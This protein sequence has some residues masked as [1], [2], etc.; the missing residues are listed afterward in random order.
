MESLV[1]LQILRPSRNS[2]GTNCPVARHIS[3]PSFELSDPRFIRKNCIGKN[4]QEHFLSAKTKKRCQLKC[5]K[6]NVSMNV[7]CKRTKVYILYFNMAATQNFLVAIRLVPVSLGQPCFVFGLVWSNQIAGKMYPEMDIR[8]TV[9]SC[10]E[11]K[12]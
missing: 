9:L 5:C 3:P 8:R 4:P 7:V 2:Q 1:C 6:L 10:H 12:K 11:L